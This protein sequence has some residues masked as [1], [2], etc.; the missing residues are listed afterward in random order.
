MRAPG[1]RGG[2][3][4]ARCGAA[5]VLPA[6][7]RSRVARRSGVAAAAR[8]AARERSAAQRR[9]CFSS[10]VDRWCSVSVSAVIVGS[11]PRGSAAP[12]ARASVRQG[13][14]L[15]HGVLLPQS[16]GRHAAARTAALRHG[17]SSAADDASSP[18]PLGNGGLKLRELPRGH[19][20]RGQSRAARPGALQ[21]LAAPSGAAGRAP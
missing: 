11:A 4:A 5:G 19:V 8:G 21:R 14:H 13:R 17:A 3:L 12:G 7:R 2:A 10:T 20:I 18:V 15:G 1:P 16:A 6:G 9:T